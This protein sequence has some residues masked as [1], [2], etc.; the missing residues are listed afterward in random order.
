MIPVI[1]FPKNKE[2]NKN[3]KINKSKRYAEMTFEMAIST[4]FI[5]YVTFDGKASKGE[6]WYWYLFYLICGIASA[7]VDVFIIGIQFENAG[8]VYWIVSLV[9]FLPTLA[10]GARRLH[11]VGKSGWWQLISITGIG[12]IPLII[13]WASEGGVHQKRYVKK[14][15]SNK[16]ELADELRELKEL[17]KE[18]TLSK[19]E[20]T[21][22]KNKL[23][24]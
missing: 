3:K 12:I 11:D 8:P 10:V 21:K 24:K 6:F 2:L 19:K 9:I 15:S 7:M 23:L 16:S 18:G 5:K 17:Y 13:W 20:F 1:P 14:T 22:A 4:C